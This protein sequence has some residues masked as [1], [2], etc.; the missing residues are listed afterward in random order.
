M[1]D[2]WYIFRIPAPSVI[3][4][5]YRGSIGNELYISPLPRMKNI[6]KHAYS[7]RCFYRDIAHHLFLTFYPLT[8]LD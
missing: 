3:I 6:Y 7:Y 1:I 2:T 5:L 8:T 4:R